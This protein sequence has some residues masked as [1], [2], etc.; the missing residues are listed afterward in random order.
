[1]ATYDPWAYESYL[2][3]FCA[4]LRD[5]VGDGGWESNLVIEMPN[6]SELVNIAGPGS[7]CTDYRRRPGPDV[8]HSLVGHSA[9]ASTLYEYLF[10]RILNLCSHGYGLW[11]LHDETNPI[12]KMLVDAAKR[13]AGIDGI[14][15]KQHKAWNGAE[16][17]RTS[18]EHHPYPP[19]PII[20][21]WIERSPMRDGVDYDFS[22][23]TG[24]PRLNSRLMFHGKVVP[25]LGIKG[26]RWIPKVGPY[27]LKDDVE[28]WY[29][30]V[31]N[32]CGD[33]IEWRKGSCPSVQ[34]T[35]HCPTCSA[36]DSSRSNSQQGQQ[37]QP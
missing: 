23:Q 2:R 35:A 17:F 26:K 5:R 32:R 18:D 12:H 8:T 11:E 25:K 15:I 6:R 28:G 7:P 37:R 30:H 22:E 4:A 16:M 33:W 3:E 27:D 21:L 24:V 10:G 20:S 29:C 13:M 31:C 19:R 34:L 14:V 9:S 1:M 36:K